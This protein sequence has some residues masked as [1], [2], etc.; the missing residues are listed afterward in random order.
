MKS[1]VII[2]GPTASGKTSLSLLLARHFKTGIISADSR[3]C[4]RELNI[5]VAKPSVADLQRIPH[6]F[7]NS[8]SV[9][10]EVNA[11]VF[12]QYALQTV[13]T[14]FEKQETAIMVGGTGL[15]IRAFCEG[16]DLI[17]AIPE[18]VRETI[19]G[20]YRNNGLEW[21][22]KE[23]QNEDPLYYASGE[24]LNPQRLMRALEVKRHTGRS[25]R[26][27]QQHKKETRSFNII[28]IALNPEKSL[29]HGRIDERIDNMMIE[30]LLEEVRSLLPF[31]E[32][33]AL[34]TVGYSE[35][36]EFIDGKVTLEEAIRNIRA[37]TKAY[38]KRQLTWFRKDQEIKWF[39]EIN[40]TEILNF[41]SRKG[42]K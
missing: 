26:E 37:N 11:A 14:I 24:T 15:Y 16:I 1:V 23:L 36:F 17:P 32:L 27:F 42:A 5:G 25:I 39:P 30:G 38:A 2:A 6:Y 10:E 40:E 12:E 9:S 31:R 33:N 19:A 20:H 13:S 8:H 34:R 28:K 35:L 29:L 18:T 21:L 7:I 4:F 3:Q 22:Q 41:V